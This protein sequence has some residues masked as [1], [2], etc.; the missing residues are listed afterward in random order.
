MHNVGIHYPRLMLL[1]YS[2]KNPRSLQAGILDFASQAD[3]ERFELCGTRRNV[4]R[5]QHSELR[6]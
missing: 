3:E 6:H 5:E 4:T 2:F 1:N